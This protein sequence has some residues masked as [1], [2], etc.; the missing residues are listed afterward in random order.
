MHAER[1][2][3][4]GRTALFVF[5]TYSFSREMYPVA[6][7]FRQK[8]W[9]VH[10]LIGWDSGW[11]PEGM[12]D[13]C[14]R[15]C[16][17]DGFV[18]HHVPLKLKHRVVQHGAATVP[19]RSLV[20]AVKNVGRH[21]FFSPLRLARWFAINIAENLAVRR[22]CRG[23]IATVRPDVMFAGAS[24]SLR[25]DAAIALA[26]VESKIPQACIP[27]S[28]YL[29]EKDAVRARFSNIDK[30]MLPPT[31]EADYNWLNRLLARNFP[32]WIRERGDKR[33]FMFDPVQMLAARLTG[34][35]PAN[36][37]CTPS[38]M[39][40]AVFVE[41]E[42]SREMLLESNYPPEKIVLTGKPLLD[43]VFA[44]LE[45]EAYR[46][47]L[48]WKLN[49][50][51]GEPFVLVNVEPSAEHHYSSWE[52]HWD[53]YHQLMGCLHKFDVKFVLSLHPLCNPD[54][55]R[56]LSEKYGFVIADGIKIAELYPY[57]SFAVSFPCSTN[58]LA[59]VFGK[60]LIMYD[61]FFM[62]TPNEHGDNNRFI[63]GAS[64]AHTADELARLIES[65]LAGA[66]KKSSAA[67]VPQ[68]AEPACEKIYGTVVSR[69]REHAVPS[70]FPSIE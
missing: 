67:R 34:L 49:V 62:A 65:H 11:S 32:G 43:A 15:T 35:L 58:L 41:S 47:E 7:Y 24:H 21:R 55:Y 23:L 2:A 50:P 33:V 14:A 6:R 42:L 28:P 56:P 27:F 44:N 13:V 64:Y 31:L 26:C 45:D 1:S 46:A 51:L 8:G 18:V 39:F 16:E 36:P 40:D 17:A 59:E 68:A 37:W 69:F 60:R 61:F 38:E 25:F 12:S 54:N 22:F 20:E 70:S 63:P 48:Y 52:A 19:E 66:E 53:R 57:C 9:A 10:V 29:G 4:C 30:G 5:S 3:D